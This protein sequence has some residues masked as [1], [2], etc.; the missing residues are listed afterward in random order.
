MKNL[1]AKTTEFISRISRILPIHE[2]GQWEDYFQF[3]RPAVFRIN[4]L[5]SSREEVSKLLVMNQLSYNRSGENPDVLVLSEPATL[6]NPSFQDM[7]NRGLLY[8]QGLS[9]LLVPLVMDPQPGERVLDLCAAPGSKATQIAALMQNQGELVCVEA[10]RKRMYKLK[11]VADLLGVKIARFCLT[12]GRRYR[13]A[14]L[15]DRILVD[16]PCSS[17]GRIDWRDP[18]LAR[19]PAGEVRPSGDLAAAIGEPRLGRAKPWAGRRVSTM[20]Y[21]SLRKIQEMVRKQRG[22]VWNAFRLLQP[23][24]VMVYSTCTFAPEE[25]EGVINWLLEKA[26]G[27]LEA[28]PVFLP[29]IPSYPTVMNWNSKFYHSQVKNCLRILPDQWREGFFIV[30]LIKAG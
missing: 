1:A 22:L 19:P 10:I 23:G 16:A 21:W 13:D 9:S 28:A 17:E 24:G 18:C 29:E 2:T 7:V 3:C 30:K 8:Q 25:N 26:E 12:D 27:A 11:A 5:R 4:T 20:A 15:F 14:E 6:K